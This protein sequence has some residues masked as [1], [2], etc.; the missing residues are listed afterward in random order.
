MTATGATD[1]EAYWHDILLDFLHHNGISEETYWWVRMQHTHSFGDAEMQYALGDNQYGHMNPAV[2]VAFDEDY[3][4]A[5]A[6][7]RHAVDAIKHNNYPHIYQYMD[8]VN[9]LQFFENSIYQFAITDFSVKFNM[10]QCLLY[11]YS[12]QGLGANSV[13]EEEEDSAV[14]AE[15]KDAQAFNLCNNLASV[16]ANQVYAQEDILRMALNC[17]EQFQN[18][19]MQLYNNEIQ[20]DDWPTYCED[21][22][23]RE[24]ISLN[25]MGFWF[26]TG[27]LPNHIRVFPCVEMAVLYAKLMMAGDKMTC[28]TMVGTG[29]TDAFRHGLANFYRTHGVV[30]ADMDQFAVNLESMYSPIYELAESE[31]VEVDY[32][33]NRYR[34]TIIPG[35]ILEFDGE[36]KDPGMFKTEMDGRLG[37]GAYTADTIAGDVT[38][39][40]LTFNIGKAALTTVNPEDDN[41]TKLDL[42]HSLF[43]T[44]LTL[45]DG[46]EFA[47]NNVVFN[48]DYTEALQKADDL[49]M[50]Y[51]TINFECAV[52]TNDQRPYMTIAQTT[53]EPAT[54]AAPETTEAVEETTAAETEAPT[55]VATE[56]STSGMML[57][58]VLLVAALF[59]LD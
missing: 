58:A 10:H 37:L 25:D 23:N 21:V 46:T 33:W 55:E 45:N 54:T 32:K 16:S 34:T 29:A 7:C 3:A 17:K 44:P 47:I 39:I 22:I 56:D 12:N 42:I 1:W 48:P 11:R 31:M 30:A 40:R 57:S 2:I 14:I 28:N 36:M 51:N 41:Q 15:Y 20:Q 9:N 53:T 13:E 18:R 5:E 59:M 6:K 50:A 27:N 8:D 26:P 38:H 4:K 52:F 43:T 35:L 49:G 24:T 19:I